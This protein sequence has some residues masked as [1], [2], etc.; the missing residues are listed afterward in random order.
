ML[1]INKMYISKGIVNYDNKYRQY[2]DL[3]YFKT[4][5]YI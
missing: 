1:I 2:K 4:F 5:K 3:F